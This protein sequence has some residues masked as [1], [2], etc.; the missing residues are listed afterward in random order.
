MINKEE[1]EKIFEDDDIDI[2]NYEKCSECG[3]WE[4]EDNLIDGMCRVCYYE[5]QEILACEE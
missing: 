2:P 3:S 5:E 4:D 1:F